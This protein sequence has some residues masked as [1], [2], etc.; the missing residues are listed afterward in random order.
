[1]DDFDF[2]FWKLWSSRFLRVSNFPLFFNR[3]SQI[4][5]ISEAKLENE[6]KSKKNELLE[7]KTKTEQKRFGS[8]E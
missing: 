2:F 6:E 5:G 8:L 3:G 1:M 4:D 7:K